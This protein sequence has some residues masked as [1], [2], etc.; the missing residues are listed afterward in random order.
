MDD[1]PVPETFG[2][3]LVIALVAAVIVGL[4]LM[5]RRS[6]QAHHRAVWEARKREQELRDRPLPEPD[7]PTQLP[8]RNHDDPPA[9][10]P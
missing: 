2:E 10:G 1:L 4:Y 8:T 7:D 6:Q 9:G 3:A 5:I